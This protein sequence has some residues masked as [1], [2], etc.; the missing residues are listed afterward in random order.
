MQRHFKD[1]LRAKACGTKELSLEIAKANKSADEAQNAKKAG[2]AHNIGAILFFL[3][4]QVCKFPQY[5][6]S[7]PIVY[8]NNHTFH[9]KTVA[10]YQP[11]DNKGFQSDPGFP[12]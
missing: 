12:G 3:P 11:L 2:N 1:I 7:L 4:G 5:H 9:Y 8:N 6:P 10:Y